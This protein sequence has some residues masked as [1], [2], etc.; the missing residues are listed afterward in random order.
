MSSTGYGEIQWTGTACTPPRRLGLYH[1]CEVSFEPGCPPGCPY[2]R[3]PKRLVISRLAQLGQNALH[4]PKL[5]LHFGAVE[6]FQ[7]A[8]QRQRRE[9]RARQP[10]LGAAAA[11]PHHL[12]VE[13]NHDGQLVS[14]IGQGY[15][16]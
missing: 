10:V 6:Q 8:K 11:V 5:Q 1:P 12:E 15:R 2:D 16:L 14:D 4:L 3:L 7:I 9:L 13:P